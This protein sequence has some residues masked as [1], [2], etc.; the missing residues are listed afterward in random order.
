MSAPRLEEP[1]VDSFTKLRSVGMSDDY[2]SSPDEAN[3]SSPPGSE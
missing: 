1:P 3:S 2:Y